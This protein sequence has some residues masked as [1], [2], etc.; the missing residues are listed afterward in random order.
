MKNCGAWHVNDM[1]LRLGSRAPRAQ[2]VLRPPGGQPAGRTT[3]APHRT[4]GAR[5]ATAEDAMAFD[6][7]AAGSAGIANGRASRWT[8][9]TAAG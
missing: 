4:A 9:P 8:F 1:R 5:E 6:L 7:P 3:T 2:T